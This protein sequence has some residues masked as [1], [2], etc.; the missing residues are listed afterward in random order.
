[1]V[2]VAAGWAG[3]LLLEAAGAEPVN[4]LARSILGELT[5]G[6][7]CGP[8][9]LSFWR[10][11]VWPV[12][13]GAAGGWLRPAASCENR[14]LPACGISRVAVSRPDGSLACI[15]F[16]ADTSGLGAGSISGLAF[17]AESRSASGEVLIWPAV[18]RR[19]SKRCCK[20][21]LASGLALGGVS[22]GRAG[23]EAP[24]CF[25]P[26]SGLAAAW[27]LR[28]CGVTV[29]AL[30]RSALAGRRLLAGAL[31][32]GWRWITFCELPADC[33]GLVVGPLPVFL[34]EFSGLPGLARGSF[35]VGLAGS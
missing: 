7:T 31:A 11:T 27:L 8:A 17:G 13:A 3:W 6:V 5:A 19:Y 28:F 35:W 15:Y 32:S 10:M 1:M 2:L 4:I 29:G 33:A 26:G 30:L 21:S 12:L 23:A 20:G 9:P 34:G 25:W 18:R 22:S 16:L 24:A 14:A